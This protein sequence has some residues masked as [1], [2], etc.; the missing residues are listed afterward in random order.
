MKLFLSSKKVIFKNEFVC[1]VL[2]KSKTH[3]I[4]LAAFLKNN[5]KKLYIVLPKGVIVW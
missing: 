2:A 1:K 3:T 5:L 4:S